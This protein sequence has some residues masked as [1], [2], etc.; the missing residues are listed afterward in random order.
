MII[1]TVEENGGN[2]RAP[3]KNSPV[4]VAGTD[5]KVPGL[6]TENEDLDSDESENWVSLTWLITKEQHLKLPRKSERFYQPET[7]RTTS[8]S[9]STTSSSE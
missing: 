6:V 7:T 1:K 4:S 2:P 9:D 8:I 5:K 3:E